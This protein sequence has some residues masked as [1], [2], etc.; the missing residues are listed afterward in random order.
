MGRRK[1][2]KSPE[3]HKAIMRVC[4]TFDLSYEEVSEIMEMGYID[5]I[6]FS[7]EVNTCK[8]ETEKA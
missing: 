1:D 3:L 4:K 5:G 7:M 6:I 8:R 2:K